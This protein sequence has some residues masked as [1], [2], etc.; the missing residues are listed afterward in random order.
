[1]LVDFPLPYIQFLFKNKEVEGV[2][3]KI[4]HISS[5]TGLIAP[6]LRMLF[7]CYRYFIN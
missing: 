1:M 3:I 5:K 4:D 2:G 6:F 7:L